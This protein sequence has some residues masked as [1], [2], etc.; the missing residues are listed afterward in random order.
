M[1]TGLDQ[2][3]GY[4]SANPSLDDVSFGPMVTVTQSAS[5]EIYLFEQ[6][7]T[8]SNRITRPKLKR[9]TKIHLN[10]DSNVIGPQPVRLMYSAIE[11]AVSSDSSVADNHSYV[12]TGLASG[13]V[14]KKHGDSWIDVSAPPRSTNPF[15]LLALLQRRIIKP[16]DEIRWVPDAE[17]QGEVSTKA[18]ELFGW[19][20]AT[21]SEEK[22]V[23]EIDAGGWSDI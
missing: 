23:V 2:T 7:P 17:D 22:T 4:Q 11:A 13:K 20:G 18:F 6:V 9:A 15:E 3:T 10:R 5:G 16:S 8:N 14:E 1:L 12:I 19:N 21:A